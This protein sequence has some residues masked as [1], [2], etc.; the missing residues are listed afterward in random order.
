ML[1]RVTSDI[2]PNTRLKILYA[3]LIIFFFRATPGIGEG[4]RWFTIDVLA[5]MKRST[6]SWARSAPPSL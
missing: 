5:S 4:Y 3:A 6:A 2:D 1:N